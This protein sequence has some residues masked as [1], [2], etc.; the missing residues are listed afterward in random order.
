MLITV[1]AFYFTGYGIYLVFY[2]MGCCADFGPFFNCPYI[3]VLLSHFWQFFFIAILLKVF[4]VVPEL[5]DFAV[6]D[7]L[8]GFALQDLKDIALRHQLKGY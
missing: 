8:K 3:L 5:K 6:G 2:Q 4:F 1:H 7:L